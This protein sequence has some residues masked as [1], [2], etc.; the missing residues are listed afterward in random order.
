MI[1]LLLCLAALYAWQRMLPP[2]SAGVVLARRR[3]GTRVVRLADWTWRPFW[4]GSLDAV[5]CRR[6][7]RLGEARIAG[8]GSTSGAASLPAAARARA[9]GRAVRAGGVT[10][11]RGV[12]P[13]HAR[14]LA[15]LVRVLAAATAAERVVLLEALGRLT[16]DAEAFRTACTGATGPLRRAGAACGVYL[17]AWLALPGLWFFAHEDLVLQAMLPILIGGHVVALA[18]VWRAARALLPDDPEARLELLT[19]AALFPP[20]LLAAPQALQDELTTAFHPAAVAPALLDA[21][22]TL[23]LFRA[24][25]AILERE[26]QEASDAAL[27]APERR[28]LRSER[29]ALLALARHLDLG[30]EALRRSRARVDPHAASYCVVC[31]ADY[32]LAVT[33]C[34]DCQVPTR[35]Y[36]D[37]AACRGNDPV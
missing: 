14:R 36:E 35:A 6:A 21:A 25:L 15:G 3:G 28:L 19:A 2:V 22:G 18:F 30:P 10:L 24:E 5:T 26:E 16:L 12:S 29:E 17:L 4:P 31:G 7:L 20:A 27:D 33:H 1:E 37:S 32:R 8:R 34:P 11:C 13:R 9:W 23:D